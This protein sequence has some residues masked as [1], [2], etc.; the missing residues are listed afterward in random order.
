MTKY[1]RDT[2]EA[3]DLK[4][5]QLQSVKRSLEQCF[6]NWT[7]EVDAPSVETTANGKEQMAKGKPKRTP[8]KRDERD[9][10]DRRT[11]EDIMGVLAAKCG[12]QFT[13]KEAAAALGVKNAS[14]SLAGP[15]RKGLV[16]RAAR[17]LWRVT[18]K[19]VHGGR[20]DEVRQMQA[21]AARTLAEPS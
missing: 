16:A 3:I 14:S 13:T 1:I 7:I 11:T 17:G 20:G 19:F 4:V 2:I 6:A 18:D 10:G 12:P 8:A 5:L 21:L 9:T 15:L